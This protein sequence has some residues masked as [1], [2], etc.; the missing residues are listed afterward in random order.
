MVITGNYAN[1]NASHQASVGEQKKMKHNSSN[2]SFHSSPKKGLSLMQ[3][4]NGM[5]QLPPSIRKPGNNILP[6]VENNF[7]NPHQKSVHMPLS[8][9][10]LPTT[11]KESKM[12]NKDRSFPIQNVTQQS[13]NK[14]MS[15][16]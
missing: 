8:N 10:V 6:I 2:Q 12:T 7:P 13:F 15:P 9:L 3:A 4:S 11:G 1:S 14:Y 16:Y 5:G